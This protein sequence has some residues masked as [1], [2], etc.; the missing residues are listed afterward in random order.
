MYRHQ[1]VTRGICAS[2]D[3]RQLLNRQKQFKLRCRSAAGHCFAFAPNFLTSRWTPGHLTIR[4]RETR[5]A[6]APHP[7]A[8]TRAR[9]TMIRIFNSKLK[10]E[11]QIDPSYPQVSLTPNDWQQD[12]PHIIIKLEAN[13]FFSHAQTCEDCL[14]FQ[15]AFGTNTHDWYI[16]YLGRVKRLDLSTLSKRPS[17]NHISYNNSAWWYGTTLKLNLDTDTKESLQALLKLYEDTSEFEACSRVL[18]KL[19]S[20]E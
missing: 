18:D 16:E 13:N 12:N 17:D 11:I 7:L 1:Q 14:S 20:T 9:Q 4:Q 2:R 19:N 5:P 6:Q 10:K 15:K 8:A 3:E